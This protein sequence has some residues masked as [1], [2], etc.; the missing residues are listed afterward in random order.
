MV[1][2]FQIKAESFLEDVNSILNSGDVPNIYASDEMDRIYG[3]MRGPVQ[4][5]GLQPTKSNLFATYCKAVRSNLHCVL[6][7]R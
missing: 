3:T 4:E 7:M 1:Y 2:S 6:T 5:A